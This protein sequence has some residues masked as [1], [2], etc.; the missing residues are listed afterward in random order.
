M[1]VTRPSKASPSPATVTWPELVMLLAMVPSPENVL[2]T[3]T[4]SLSVPSIRPVA[5]RV[6]LL[7]RFNEVLGSLMVSVLIPTFNVP[8]FPSVS[9]PE[10][11]GF[12]VSG[13]VR[14]AVTVVKESRS[15]PLRTPWSE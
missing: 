6:Q 5:P 14:F 12:R 11:L 7:R 3:S 4:L 1:P 15:S 9:P 13:P 8:K 2:P 10:L